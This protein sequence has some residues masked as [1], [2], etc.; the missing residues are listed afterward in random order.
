MPGDI[1]R[2]KIELENHYFTALI[3]SGRDYQ[4]LLTLSKC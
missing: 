2:R 4:L 1:S 3:D